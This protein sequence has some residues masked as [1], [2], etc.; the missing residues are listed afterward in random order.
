[1]IKAHFCSKL[2]YEFLKFILAK[3]THL[4]T[5]GMSSIMS[6]TALLTKVSS[7]LTQESKPAYAYLHLP[8]KNA[9]K[10]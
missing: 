5:E 9:S 3:R 8:C 4:Y 10:K 7:K 2:F 1:M 6:I